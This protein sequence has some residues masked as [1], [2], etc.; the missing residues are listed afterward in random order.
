MPDRLL[1]CCSMKER[2]TDEKEEDEEFIRSFRMRERQTERKRE[3]NKRERERERERCIGFL[4]KKKANG[5][6]LKAPSH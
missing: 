4:W 1:S 3:R 5:Q 2:G 6:L